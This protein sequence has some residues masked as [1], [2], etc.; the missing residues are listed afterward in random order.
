MG[1]HAAKLHRRGHSCR[2]GSLKPG[3]AMTSIDSAKGDGASSPPPPGM[4]VVRQVFVKSIT[5]C[6]V[7]VDADLS[8]DICGLVVLLEDKKELPK[9]DVRYTFGSQKLE[10]GVP[11]WRYGIR[12]G[13]NIQTHVCPQ[14][15]CARSTSTSPKGAWWAWE[16]AAHDEKGTTEMPPSRHLRQA[17]D[18]PSE[19]VVGGSSSAKQA[20]AEFQLGPISG[21]HHDAICRNGGCARGATFEMAH[22][23]AVAQG[24]AQHGPQYGRSGCPRLAGRDLG[25]QQLAI[26]TWGYT[27]FSVCPP[28]VVFRH[29][30]KVAKHN[31]GIDVTAPDDSPLRQAS[32]LVDEGDELPLGLLDEDRACELHVSVSL[33]HDTELA[34][35]DVTVR[36]REPSAAVAFGTTPE[37]L[38]LMSSVSASRC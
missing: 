8:Q 22:M 5:G 26:E 21:D 36:F 28:A 6:S 18:C 31:S 11:L 27:S 34:V 38:C 37:Q 30:E 10:P 15:G 14:S 1:A 24:I 23:Q 16:E 29:L 9:T 19:H 12:K 3:R 13:S 7:A 2:V 35:D 4:D 25:K 17:Q 33:L 32:P 20:K